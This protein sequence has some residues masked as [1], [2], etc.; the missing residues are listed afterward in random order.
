[1]ARYG[2]MFM[3]RYSSVVVKCSVYNT[4]ASHGF[5]LDGYSNMAWHVGGTFKN[6]LICYFFK[7]Q[8]VVHNALK[9]YII[10]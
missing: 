8:E 1:M 7:R 10:L 4:N 2:H 6:L 5:K 9:S 3:I